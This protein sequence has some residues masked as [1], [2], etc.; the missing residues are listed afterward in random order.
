MRP[1]LIFLLLLPL[2]ACGQIAEAI[3]LNSKFA[4][5]KDLLIVINLDQNGYKVL[6]HSTDA[7][8][9]TLMAARKLVVAS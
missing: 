8:V 6:G 5:N 7:D 4:E 2:T 1:S 3:N 9:R